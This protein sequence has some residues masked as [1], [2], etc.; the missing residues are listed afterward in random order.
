MILL[1]NQH[2]QWFLLFSKLSFQYTSGIF[3]WKHIRLCLKSHELSSNHRISLLLVWLTPKKINKSLQEQ[4][5]KYTKYYHNVLKRVMTKSCLSL[6]NYKFRKTQKIVNIQK[7]PIKYIQTSNLEEIV[8]TPKSVRPE[9]P[10]LTICPCL[11]GDRQHT[12]SCSQCSLNNLTCAWAWLAWY[13]CCATT[14]S[15]NF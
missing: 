12:T 15:Y 14:F 1:F 9:P 13:L 3:D 7:V 6:Y 5:R 4:L 11:F 10:K 8:R 2:R